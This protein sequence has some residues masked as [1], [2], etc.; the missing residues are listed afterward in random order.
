[1]ADAIIREGSET[2]YQRHQNIGNL[3]S[4][5]FEIVM[6]YGK[7][8]LLNIVLFQKRPSRQYQDMM[9]PAGNAAQS[10][11]QIVASNCFV[12]DFSLLQQKGFKKW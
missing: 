8:K 10:V 1:M 5:G 7:R 2:K 9:V 12:N 4:Q 6:E 11:A 3:G